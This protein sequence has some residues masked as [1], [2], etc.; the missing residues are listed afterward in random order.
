MLRVH[1]VQMQFVIISNCLQA[2]I[3]KFV[4]KV[5]ADLFNLHSFV[6]HFVKALIPHALAPMPRDCHEVCANRDWI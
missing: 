5:P 1:A 6:F 3:N 2:K 4:Q